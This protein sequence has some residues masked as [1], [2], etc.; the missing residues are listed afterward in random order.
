MDLLRISFLIRR[1]KTAIGLNFF[2]PE[3]F[4]PTFTA[5][6]FLSQISG[7]TPWYSRKGAILL[8]HSAA[9]LVFLSAPYFLRPPVE[10]KARAFDPDETLIL[11]L[12][13]IMD[14][15]LILSFYLNA[16]VL[17]P[18]MLYTG[19][20]WAFAGAHLT[21]IS[22]LLGGNWLFVRT[23][24]IHTALVWRPMLFFSI[25]PYFFVF[26]SSCAYQLVRDRL[27]AQRLLKDRENETLRTEL[28]F[29]RSQVSP[30]FMFNVLNNMVALARKGSPDLEPSLIK[31]SQLMRYMLYETDEQK[32]PLEKE[33]EYLQAYIDLQRQRF[34]HTVKV[35]TDMRM[36][37]PVYIIEPMLLI[38]LVEN[39][40]KHGTGMIGDA[41]IDIRLT[42][43]NGCLHF[44]V[45][46]KFNPSTAETRDNTPGIGLPN[47]KRR[48]NLLY[49]RQHALSTTIDENFYTTSL[50]IN[51]YV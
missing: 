11:L 4:I 5:M 16:L 37:E 38:P 31:L 36:Q 15:W 20:Q 51:F 14:C 6:P 2:G 45:R 48:L 43:A 35:S 39:A 24:A 17:M 8:F 49:D 32:V 28:S 25:F 50:K 40:F 9:W 7:K 23:A 44:C 34:G 13:G 21:L 42:A 29:L 18:K 46:N 26:A 19:R 10:L 33:I 30:H 47:L 41:E 22:I 12:Q 3:P 1:R 27:K